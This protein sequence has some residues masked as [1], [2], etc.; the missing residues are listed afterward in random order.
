MRAI[1]R[2]EM[3]RLN[4]RVGLRK[5]GGRGGGWE[6]QGSS[7]VHILRTLRK[8]VIRLDGRSNK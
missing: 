2:H 3:L 6:L 8:P 4:V 1:R 5:F 7:M